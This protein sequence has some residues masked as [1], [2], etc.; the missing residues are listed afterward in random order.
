MN[1]GQDVS[2]G[3]TCRYK[4]HNHFTVRAAHTLV[5]VERQMRGT[6]G[7]DKDKLLLGVLAGS[8]NEAAVHA[9]HQVTASAARTRTPFE[10]PIMDQVV[11]NNVC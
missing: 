9:P 8:Q 5:T 2:D 6:R 7:C 1:V 11:E 4:D 3:C 10:Y